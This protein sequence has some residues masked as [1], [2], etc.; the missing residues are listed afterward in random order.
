MAANAEA[1]R[2]VVFVNAVEDEDYLQVQD[3]V[4]EFI[5]NNCGS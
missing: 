4:E 5:L 3:N 1:G 2:I